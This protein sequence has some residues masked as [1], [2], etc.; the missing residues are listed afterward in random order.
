MSVK[1]L[2]EDDKCKFINKELVGGKN[3]A[4]TKTWGLEHWCSH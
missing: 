3:A 4:D 2:K 1:H